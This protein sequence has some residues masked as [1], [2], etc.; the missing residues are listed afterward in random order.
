MEEEFIKEWRTEAANVLG[1]GR[2]NI[3]KCCAN[4]C[5]SSRGGI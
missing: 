4:K 2:S 3:S 5:N 1:I